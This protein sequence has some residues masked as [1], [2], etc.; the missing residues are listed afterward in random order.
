MAVEASG[1][2][3]DGSR[4]EA[5]PEE[6]CAALLSETCDS[7]A[8]RAESTFD[9]LAE[10]PTRSGGESL[11]LFG[12]G[13][14]GRLALSGLRSLGVEPLAFADSNPSLWGKTVDGVPI[15]SPEE[16]AHRYGDKAAFVITIWN[17][18]ATDRMADRRRQLLD[19]G[20]STVV[21]FAPLFWKYPGTF[22]PH[23]CID[24]PQ[25]V[26]AQAR[27]VQRAL[28]LWDD[29]ASRDEYV[30]QLEWRMML[31]FDR[32][33]PPIWPPIQSGG[34]AEGEQYFPEDLFRLGPS[35]V[36][37]DVGAFDGDT[38]SSFIKRRGNQFN[39]IVA[40]EPDPAN[41]RSLVKYI[42]SLPG[43]I[44]SRI[45]LRQEAVGARRER[46]PS[47]LPGRTWRLSAPRSSR[48][49]APDQI[50][51][52][53]SRW[54]VYPLTRL[55]HPRPR[56]RGHGDGRGDRGARPPISRWTSRAPN[57]MRW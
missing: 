26:L 8:H 18:S 17:N 47:T 50:G 28:A 49:L 41:F 9:R 55:W 54:S 29:D 32:L 1:P 13:R 14:L 36:F 51:G 2:V 40:F 38:L 52:G 25:K 35:E 20:C 44:R 24:L 19:R 42:G 27:D 23:Y 33:L 10:P 3:K 53:P 43:D 39:S 7:A 11:V 30:R 6:R 4:R 12:A 45:A 5:S 46:C 21:P 48:G 22:L 34:A 37:L 57:S 15:L 56:P 31:D 16:S